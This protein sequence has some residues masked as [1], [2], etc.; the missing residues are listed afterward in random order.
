[1]TQETIEA[2]EIIPGQAD[3]SLVASD[4][5]LSFWGG[6]DPGN[7]RVI[8]S[9]HPL[10]GRSVQGNVLAIPSGRGS[11][12]GSG[13]MLE[14]LLQ[15]RAPSA[16]IFSREELILP[17]G[18][19]VAQELFQK[20]IPV[21]QVSGSSFDKLLNFDRARIQNARI[22]LSNEALPSPKAESPL[23]V[24]ATDVD[25]SSIQLTPLDHE[26]L[27]GT[28]GRAA[29][30]AMRIILRTALIQGVT[31][32]IDVKQA[33]IDCCIYT[34]PAT[35]KFAQQLC[36]WGGKLRIPT[37]LNAI[38]IDRR[39]WR[40]QGVDPE[41]GEP[42][43]RLAQA[44]LHM[45]ARPTFTCAPYLLET[46]PK[47]GDHIMWAESNAVVFANS[48]L[49]A[50]TIKCPDFLDV[51]VALTG[52]TLNSGC[53]LEENRKAHI[54]IHIDHTED[55]D[56]TLFP[57]LGYI[58]GD[59]AADVVPIITGLESTK[60]TMADLKAF[61]AA[62]ATTSS[63]PMFHIAGVTVEAM[64]Q[65][66]ID[67]HLRDTPR[68]TV[69]RADLARQWK[70]FNTFE[71]E[72]SSCQIDLVSLGNPHFAFEEI[73]R[74]VGLLQGRQKN[75]TTGI[76]VTCNR[77]TYSQ[78]SKAG[79][80]AVL[81]G[82][83]VQIVTDTCWCMIQEPVIPRETKVIMTNSGKYAHYGKGLTGRHIRF[84]G[85]EQCAAAGCSGQATNLPP[86]WLRSSEAS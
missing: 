55:A 19:L 6:V 27:N 67:F 21:L 17:I 58:A 40:S 32:L 15:D 2:R 60:A 79:L 5:A 25:F 18:V 74:L 8:D 48:V 34:G 31:E 82:H 65:Q 52:R 54:E 75:T 59:L 42:S 73:Q 43:E 57:L 46:A 69:S 11:C 33:H 28:H 14:L 4:V 12:T 83:G 22:Y 66:Q 37:S 30:V 51:C 3:G 41:L 86:A 85:L 39:L 23:N 70:R 29:Q 47:P 16:L 71:D 80:I 1:M 53:H 9:H 62:F 20:S 7:G 78:A 35:L 26:L 64:S 49:G 24:S 38:S 45:G 77:A 13:I 36:D 68:S 56:D 63:A 81:E 10:V 76:M 84:G 50:R 44:Y 72:K 61:G